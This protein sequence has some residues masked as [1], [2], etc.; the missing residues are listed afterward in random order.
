MTHQANNPWIN[1][2]HPTAKAAANQ[3]HQRVYNP[4]TTNDQ[5]QPPAPNNLMAQYQYPPLTWIPYPA[6]Y[7]MAMPAVVPPIVPFVLLSIEYCFHHVADILI[8]TSPA[9]IHYPGSPSTN[10]AVQFYST[11]VESPTP[12]NYYQGQTTAQVNAHNQARAHHAG[13]YNPNIQMVPQAA[14]P[15]NE[16]W[17][18][19]LNGEYT[20]RTMNTIM[21]SL[22]PGVWARGSSGYPYFV[23][24]AKRD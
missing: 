10:P 9:P 17:C 7:P 4:A 8:Q 3:S 23:R 20:L 11:K 13:A 24:H 21:N 2:S 22:Q 14:S 5:C 12:S 6:Y 15:D 18:R 19:E 16:F 1:P